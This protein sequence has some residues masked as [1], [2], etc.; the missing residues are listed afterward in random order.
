MRSH[1]AWCFALYWGKAFLKVGVCRSAQLGEVRIPFVIQQP[2]RQ[3]IYLP[4]FNWNI[5]QILMTNTAP[6]RLT[7]ESA[8]SPS[9]QRQ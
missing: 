1:E 3:S 2:G 7:D 6:T 8:D 9:A 4:Y 5:K